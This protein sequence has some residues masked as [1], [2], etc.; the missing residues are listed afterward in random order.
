MYK[1]NKQ[2]CTVEV[3]NIVQISCIHFI[4]PSR[5]KYYNDFL[6]L[7]FEFSLNAQLE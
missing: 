2:T 6:V 4:I 3:D 5:Y 7:H 1:S